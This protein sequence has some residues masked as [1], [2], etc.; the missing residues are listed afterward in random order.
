MGYEIVS[1]VVEVLKE[2]GFIEERIIELMITR[3]V[4]LTDKAELIREGS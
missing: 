4:K 2:I 3:L 1:R